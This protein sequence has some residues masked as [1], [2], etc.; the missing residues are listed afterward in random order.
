MKPLS[1]QKHGIKAFKEDRA[2]FVSDVKESHMMEE[3]GAFYN[4]I[5]LFGYGVGKSKIYD[6]F[7]DAIITKPIFQTRNTG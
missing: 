6:V 4:A 2:A 3:G 7:S 5:S 1:F